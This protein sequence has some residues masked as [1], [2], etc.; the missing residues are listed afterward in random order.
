VRP[1]G[2]LTL[3]LYLSLGQRHDWTAAMAR[4]RAPVLVLH[5]EE[6]LQPRAA[7]ERVAA[8]FPNSRLLS[9]PGAGH[10]PFDEQPDAFAQAV[11][12]FLREQR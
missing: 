5:G 7:T 9:L 6:D 8:L 2:F 3:A 12:E 1:G 4:V 10:F 11:S